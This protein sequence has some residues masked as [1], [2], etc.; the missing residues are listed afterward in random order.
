M[1]TFYFFDQDP[2]YLALGT[3]LKEEGYTVLT[4]P[5]NIPKEPLFYLFPLGQKEKEVLE[6]LEKT[7]KGSFALVGKETPTLLSFAKEKGIFLKGAL[8]D[9]IYLFRNAVATAEGVLKNV[10]EK[11]NKTL[12]ELTVLIYGYGN[13]GNAIARLLWLCGCEVFVTS[14]E[15]GRKKAEKDGFNIHWPQ[16]NSLSMFD[17]VVNTVPDPVFTDS[18]LLSMQEDSHFFQVATGLSGID[19]N[20]LSSHGIHFHPLPRLPGLYAPQSEAHAL[21]DLIFRTEKAGRSKK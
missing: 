3:L 20:I 5:E 15:R 12:D 2:R 16:E 19:P 7:E 17:A 10:I 9:E 4:P 1:N 8:Q 13:C 21:Y 18:L 14:R 6:I 11:C